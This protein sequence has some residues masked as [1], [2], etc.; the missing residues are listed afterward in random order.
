MGIES[1]LGKHVALPRRGASLGP[2]H[3]ILVPQSHGP[4]GKARPWFPS[5][6]G[7]F[8]NVDMEWFSCTCLGNGGQQP[9]DSRGVGAPVSASWGKHLEL[10]GVSLNWAVGSRLFMVVPDCRA[11]GGIAGLACW[12]RRDGR[13]GT[14]TRGGTKGHAQTLYCSGGSS[15]GPAPTPPPTP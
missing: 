12:V 3:A 13:P 14:E 10:L 8:R 15:R 9:A 1:P 11:T 4:F 2:R 5:V 7:K 6:T